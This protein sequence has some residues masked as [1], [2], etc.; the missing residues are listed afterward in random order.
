MVNN[1]F[2]GDSVIAGIG[3]NKLLGDLICDGLD[4]NTLIAAYFINRKCT[5]NEYVQVFRIAN[6]WYIRFELFFFENCFIA[7]MGKAGSQITFRFKMLVDCFLSAPVDD[8][9]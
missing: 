8:S 9:D 7:Y 6:Y 2:I 5:R 4:E 3:N 1:N